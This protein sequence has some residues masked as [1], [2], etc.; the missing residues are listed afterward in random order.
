ME[1]KCRQRRLNFFTEGIRF[2]RGYGGARAAAIFK[3]AKG[4]GIEK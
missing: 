2:C 3:T 1:E 4:A